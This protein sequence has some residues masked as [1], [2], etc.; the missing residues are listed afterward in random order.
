MYVRDADA[1]VSLSGKAELGTSSVNEDLSEWYTTTLASVMRGVE[2]LDKRGPVAVVNECSKYPYAHF[3]V[4][5][6]GLPLTAV[7]IHGGSLSRPQSK[8]AAEVS[9]FSEIERVV[10]PSF[11]ADSIDSAPEASPP[12]QQNAGTV[13]SLPPLQSEPDTA[14][15]NGADP[16]DSDFTDFQSS[17]NVM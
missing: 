10:G 12:I 9:A 1:V 15:E 3:T 17:S 6:C 5:V 2:H 14:T 11:S 13:V 7:D 4:P 8:R 16:T